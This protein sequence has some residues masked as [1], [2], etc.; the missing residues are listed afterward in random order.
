VVLNINTGGGTLVHELTHA[1][2]DFDFPAI[3]DWFNEGLASLHEQC[4]IRTDESGIDGLV[5]WRLPGLQDVIRQGRLPSIEQLIVRNDFRGRDVGLN[6][7]QARYLCL[8][9]QQRGQLERYYYRF[10]Q[11]QSTDPQG[12]AT[13]LELFPDC[14]WGEIDR[15]FQEW[16]LQLELDGKLVSER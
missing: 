5:N 14:D 6:Y 3:P 8:F 16:V 7:A 13:L 1:L 12:L 2:A 4:R 9:L 15:Q 11:Q 10:R